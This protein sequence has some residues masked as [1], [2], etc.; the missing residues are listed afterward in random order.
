M[1]IN[2]QVKSYLAASV[3]AFALS[4]CGGSAE[5]NT[6][7]V[8]IDPAAPVSDWQMV[9]SDEFDGNGINANNWTLE[10]D[11]LG[12]GNNEQQC[13]T[14]S[15]ENAFVQDGNLN[16]VALA[17]P[18]GSQKPYTS[19]RINT[20]YKADFKYGRFEMRARLPEGQGTWPA[21]WM[22][23][24]DEVYGSWPKSGEIDIVEA[25]NLKVQGDDGAS[26]NRI[27]GTLHYGRDFPNNVSSGKPY[28]LPDGANPADDFHTYTIEW[29]EGEIRWYMDGYLYQ[30]QRQS[31]V[32]FNSRDEAVGLA[33]RG[34]FAE[35]FD[36][37][38]GDLTTFWNSAP[39]DQEF[40]LILNLAVG[41]SFPENTNNGGIDPTAFTNGQSLVVD[42]VRVY[43][44]AT[45]PDT[46][47]GCET[48]RAGYDSPDDALTEGRAPF[49]TPPL[50][51]NPNASLVI[52]DGT[53]NPN[54]PAWDCCGG[55]T[56]ALIDDEEQGTVYEFVVNAEPTV[57]GF[58]TRSD[59]I[60]DEAGSPT[61]FDARGI[62]ETG[63]VSFDVKV[64]SQPND[65][66]AA[67]LFK[68][69]SQEGT[70][71]VEIPVTLSSEGV[72]PPTGEWQTYT[73]P[74]SD[75]ADR[76]L[77]LSTIDV[78]ML[79]P[80]W[81]LGE[82]A[83]YRMANV[84]IASDNA[85]GG[86]GGGTGSGAQVVMFEDEVNPSWP[87]WD[88]CGGTTPTVEIDDD[89]HGNVAQFSIGAQPTVMGFISRPDFTDSPSPFD[90][91]SILSNGVVQFELKVINEPSGAD[92]QWLF[93]IESDNATTAVEIPV[94]TSSEGVTPTTGEWQTYTFPLSELA[95]AGL[96]VS[97]IDVV[98][99]FPTWEQ[100]EDALYRI[101]N[102]KIYN[103]NVSNDFSGFVLF[104]EAPR[105]QWTIWNCC[106][107]VAPTLE[108][109]D[110]EHG[111]TAEFT[112]GES[113]TVTGIWAEDGVYLDATNLLQTGVVSL[114]M[115]VI[116]PPND[117][118]SVWKFKI[119]S[120]DATTAVELDLNASLEGVDPVVGEWQTYT[121]NLTDLF[122]AGL[123]VSQI[124]VVMVFP[125]WST[126][127]GAV[128]R[129]DNVM[130][131][132]P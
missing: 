43:E 115:K 129:L 102:M 23:S 27:F 41:G 57:N 126:G 49:P 32:R 42:Y 112:V 14:E 75:L 121:F 62:E 36:A 125:A 70:T 96:D 30:T 13:Y 84:K 94:T 33:H 93:K 83:V 69:E 80:T 131:T 9:W 55:S 29:Q 97:A 16:I 85:G 78:I 35:Y 86:S 34:W 132:Q 92:A 82:G 122:D 7:T 116:S 127:E 10:V 106:G 40:H 56:P 123:D 98:M 65:S 63:S 89:A 54:W 15:P 118:A 114:E 104:E 109:D 103:P 28:A 20:R 107:E 74:L 52:F 120:S 47:R 87:M 91:T 66:S 59:F 26:E 21:F 24:T 46:G 3:A 12:G 110:T 8:G 124:D 4:G 5:T 99:V 88:C 108:A 79:F 100:G 73:F 105:D 45:D 48:I 81:T 64:V 44:C 31:D 71:A 119:E 77:D 25:V 51:D 76:G 6:S 22:L 17:A 90:A 68:I 95:N 50:V 2:T 61:P 1:K 130:I 117:P 37:I 111:M 39:Y 58:I 60:T 67:W 72:A 11:C 38:T 19:A 113:P 101:D 18:E 53:P 128:Y